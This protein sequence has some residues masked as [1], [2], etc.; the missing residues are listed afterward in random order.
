MVQVVEMLCKVD[1]YYRE[2]SWGRTLNDSVFY[3][4][5]LRVIGRDC[6]L[7]EVLFLLGI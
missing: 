6:H 7:L 3:R 2:L 5:S 4:A 1:A